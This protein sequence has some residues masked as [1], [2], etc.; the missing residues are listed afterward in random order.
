MLGP[1][2]ATISAMEDTVKTRAIDPAAGRGP[3]TE[4]LSRRVAEEDFCF[5]PGKHLRACLE[6][7]SASALSDWPRFQ[8]SWSDMPLDQYM[9]DGGRYRRRRH[10]TLSALP[11]SRVAHLEAH[12][13]HYQSRDYNSLNGGI[14]RHFEPI[15]AD[16]VEG[17]TMSSIL[18][19]CCDVFGRLLPGAAWHIE[20]HQFRIEAKAGQQGS[21]TPEGNHRDGVSFVLVM[22][23]QRSNIASGT[24]T[25]YDLGQRRLDS[26]TLTEPLDAAI[27]NDER[28]MHG[29]T[30]VVQLDPAR[31]A[32]RDVLVVTFRKR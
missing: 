17:A 10:A 25:I 19:F 26:F 13:P 28:C 4:A 9:A 1:I 23:V 16:V 20:V 21:P 18:S 32:Y 11:A 7:V 14:P 29:V 6:Q 27:V 24:T 12:Q 22:M 5:V 2:R 3:A 15:A 31:P 30:P 8:A